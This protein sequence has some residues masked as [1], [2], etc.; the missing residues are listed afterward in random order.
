M[1]QAW[2]QGGVSVWEFTD[3]ENP[4]EIAYFDRTPFDQNELETAGSW[5]AYY[6]NGH[7]YSSG[8]QE[9]LDV[10]DLRDERTDPA[11]E[12]QFD[13]FNPQTQPVYGG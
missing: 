1:V 13:E 11:K 9:G 2:Y 8:I 12:V 5:S 3:P 7:I 4:R 6:Y 10:L